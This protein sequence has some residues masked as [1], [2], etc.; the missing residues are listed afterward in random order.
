M[1]RRRFP[2]SKTIKGLGGDEVWEMEERIG[3][4]LSSI[5]I[6]TK[7]KKVARDLKV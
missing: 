6:V 5:T 4:D 1:S 2:H 3:R 7:E